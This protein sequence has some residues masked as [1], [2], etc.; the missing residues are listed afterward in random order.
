MIESSPASCPVCSQT[1]Q[2]HSG[3]MMR[4]SGQWLRFRTRECLNSF[5]RD[6]QAYSAVDG[7]EPHPDESPCTEWACY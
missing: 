2:E 6:P 5:G 3:W 1:L 7:G 4:R